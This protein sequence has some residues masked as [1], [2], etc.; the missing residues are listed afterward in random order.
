[1][2]ELIGDDEFAGKYEEL[3][4]L[5]GRKF[6]G[7]ENDFRKLIRHDAVLYLFSDESGEKG[8]PL[9][10]RPTPAS[11]SA[12]WWVYCTEY[13]A[14]RKIADY[15]KICHRKRA[16]SKHIHEILEDLKDG[17]ICQEDFISKIIEGYAK[18]VMTK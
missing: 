7:D 18:D 6:P 8:S 1:M 4:G 13:L 3:L 16:E 2:C 11:D 15:L 9:I 17:S 5:K 14:V 12:D 10:E